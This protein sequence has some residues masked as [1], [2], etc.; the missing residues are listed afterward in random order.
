MS[1]LTGPNQT[2]QIIE[3]L[4]QEWYADG[5][6]VAY[7]LEHANKEIITAW[8][9]LVVKNLKTWDSAKPYLALHDLS[10]PGVVMKFSMI[11][12]NLLNLAV[13][14]Q[15]QQQIDDI[16]SPYADFRAQVAILV[17]IQLSGY[18]ASTFA[19]FE[20]LRQRSKNISYRVFTERDSALKWLTAEL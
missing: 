5:R 1:D 16:V 3:G 18:L 2:E 6:L 11:Q 9:E 17:S 8:S 15:A 10:Y 12:K 13:T 14:D 7:R 20:A 4:Y 19:E